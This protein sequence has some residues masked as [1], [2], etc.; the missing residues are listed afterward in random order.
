MRDGR[1]SFFCMK[2]SRPDTCSRWR[3][4]AER[5]IERGGVPGARSELPRTTSASAS[6][7][8][9]AAERTGLPRG[10]LPQLR[11]TKRLSPR[12]ARLGLRWR[13]S[14][15]VRASRSGV[16]G[17]PALLTLPPPPPPPPPLPLLA[18]LTSRPVDSKLLARLCT[19]P[20]ARAAVRSK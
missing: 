4:V 16:I 6:S 2:T 5:G 19:S 8:R 12:T 3:L 1:T 15:I 11:G 14:S 20:T 13:S 10:S 9:R 7:T 18:Q 17:V